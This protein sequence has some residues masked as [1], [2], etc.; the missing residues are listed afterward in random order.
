MMAPDG[1]C[2]TFDAEANGI[3][4]GEGCGVLVLKRLSDAII[5]G[6]NILALIRGSAVNQDGASSGF[7][8]PNKTA[9]E[10]LIRQALA[11]AKV[12]PSEVD[13]VEAHGTGTPLGDPIEVRALGAVLGEG[14]S[15]ETPLKIGSVKTNIGHLESAA[16]VASLIKVVLSL[17]NQQLPPHL[18][19]KQPNPYINWDELPVS[20]TTESMAWSIGEKR[21]IAGV[22]SFGASGTNAHLVLEE[23]PKLEPKVESSERP[24]HVLT[25]SAKTKEALN[26]LGDRYEKH[27]ASNPALALGNVSFTSNTGRGHFKHRL[28]VLA[29]ST[30]KVSEK[31]AA[32]ARGQEASGVLLGQVEGTT[33]PKVAFLF[34]GQGSQ[35]VGMGRQLY[36]TQ[37]TFRAALD[38]CAEILRPYLDKPLLEILYPQ[39]NNSSLPNLLDETAYTQPALFA[40]EYALFELWKS[41]GIQPSVVM[42]HS[43]GEYVAACVAGAL[44]LEEGLKLI[45]ARGRLMQAPAP[46]RGDGCPAS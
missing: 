37:P 7:T 45:A 35:Y 24:L 16:G 17:Q 43:V 19:L 15:P 25:L 36:D 18:H 27:L 23:A 4:R 20:V 3:V 44:T 10:T 22:S 26:Q 5:D 29:N 6:D 21:R 11:R 9:Q 39:S 38:R 12:A 34:T 13:Y 40:L 31:L 32:F 33:P 42:G 46:N 41:W 1:R 28:A 30:T 14:R 2:K 8:V